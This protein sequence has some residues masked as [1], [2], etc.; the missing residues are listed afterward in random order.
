M[1]ERFYNPFHKKVEETLEKSGK[2]TGERILG[3]D[4]KSGRQVSVKI[5]PYGP[6]VQLGT[7]EEEEKPKFAGLQKGQHI[8]TITLEE[9]LKLFNLPRSLGEYEEEEVIVSSGRYGPYVKH[10]SK[11][12]SLKSQD[13]PFKITLERA[14]EL[15][16][17]K[18]E[19]DRK[20]TIKSFSKDPDLIVLKGR[21]GPYI[22]Y[23]DGNYR[24][25]KDREAEKLTLEDCYQII[26]EK[27]E[28]DSKKGSGKSGG[29]K[30]SSTTRKK[31]SKSGSK[32]SGSK[33]SG[34]K[35]TTTKKT[36]AKTSGK[37]TGTKKTGTRQSGSKKSSTSKSSSSG[38][39]KGAGG[40]GSKKSST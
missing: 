3:T 5:G 19:R 18:R 23:S 39:K 6:M 28:R 38:N 29:S 33:S 12:F 24:I 4:P 14:I 1:I 9:A 21:F 20:R 32:S 13:D 22:S 35:K 26:Q 31:T 37:Q 25:P 30:K 17:E 16:E 2:N 15:I 10:R 8:E 7:R 40:S 11:Y 34:K 27:K 36:T